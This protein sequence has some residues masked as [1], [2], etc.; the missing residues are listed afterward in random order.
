MT[1]IRSWAVLLVAVFWSAAAQGQPAEAPS[2]ASANPDEIILVT[3]ATG[4]VG[5]HIVD[6]L[7][8]QGYT[9][10][11]MTR[12]V[13]RASSEIREDIEWIQGDVRE[14]ASLGAAFAGVSK[15]I[16]A[17]GSTRDPGNGAEAVDYEGAKNQVAAA[18]A[19]GA[20]YF[21]LITSAGVTHEDHYLNQV[22]D[23]ML[24][25][26]FRGEEALRDSGL[27][28]S[29]VRPGGL[30]PFPK[31][32]NGILLIQGD[33]VVDGLISR[34]DVAAVTIECLT[35]PDALNK[36]FEIFNYLNMEA[37]AWRGRFVELAAD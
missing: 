16:S 2:E 36:T 13:E 34:A 1:L 25:W 24:L 7:V 21:V 35:N 11:G 32:E 27:P 29:I 3:G 12:N 37:G 26:K 15:V 8:E 4:R 31:D 19:A 18:K 23:N 6:Q 17:I 33:N 10:R 5:R 22:A 28:Y 20:S 30:R 9:V 14:P